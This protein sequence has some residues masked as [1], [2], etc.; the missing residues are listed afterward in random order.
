MAGERLTCEGTEAQCDM[1]T[2]PVELP[3]VG[4][5]TARVSDQ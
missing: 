3:S 5:K 4:V 1:R 2:A